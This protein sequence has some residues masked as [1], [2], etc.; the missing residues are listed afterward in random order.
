[1]LDMWIVEICYVSELWTEDPT[2]L[3]VGSG[4]KYP[5]V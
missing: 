3:S 4:Y 2:V 1:M 5:K